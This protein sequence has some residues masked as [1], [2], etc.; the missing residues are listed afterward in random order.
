[1]NNFDVIAGNVCS[2]GAMI[3]DSYSGTRKNE[4]GILLA[5]CVSQIFYAAGSI[6]LKGYSAT[7][8]NVNF[9]SGFACIFT[10]IVTVTSLV[11]EKSG[12]K[13]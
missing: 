8:Q 12:A 6:I 7:V 3:S 10:G 2:I 13:E 4:K 5:Q 9:V 1:M 11:K